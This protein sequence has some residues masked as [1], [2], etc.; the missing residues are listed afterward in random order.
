MLFKELVL[1]G[2]DIAAPALAELK[3]AKHVLSEKYQALVAAKDPS[4]AADSVYKLALEE[5]CFYLLSHKDSLR[6]E[7]ILLIVSP[8]QSKLG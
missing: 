2:N 6:Y 1:K 3:T 5:V 8:R 4:K 7:A